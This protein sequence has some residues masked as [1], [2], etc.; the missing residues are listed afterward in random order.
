MRQI[1]VEPVYGCCQSCTTPGVSRNLEEDCDFPRVDSASQQRAT[2]CRVAVVP[3]FQ[4][5]LI[6][7]IEGSKR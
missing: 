4:L 5:F 2:S 1:H 3:S 6:P 7:F